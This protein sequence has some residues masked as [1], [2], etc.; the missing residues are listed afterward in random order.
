MKE[1]TYERLYTDLDED[2]IRLKIRHD[3]IKESLVIHLTE[4]QIRSI[5]ET[6]DGITEFE[7]QQRE[8]SEG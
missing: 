3:A 8:M 1:K 2:Y 6:A 5:E 4:E 7:M